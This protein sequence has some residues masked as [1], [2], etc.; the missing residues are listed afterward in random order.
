M[1][2]TV[3]FRNGAVTIGTRSLVA[4]TCHVCGLILGRKHYQRKTHTWA[5]VC[6][7]CSGKRQDAQ[8]TRDHGDTR[9]AYYRD[10]NVTLETAT[11]YG[12][13]WTLSDLDRVVELINEGKT[14]KQIAVA[15]NRSFGGVRAAIARFEL[16]NSW[17]SR[18]QWIITLP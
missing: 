2:K 8:G 10:Q 13:Y 5:N 17:P 6:N 1:T 11:R 4:R 3:A 15:V 7:S 12:S 9:A 14:I 16:R 18:E